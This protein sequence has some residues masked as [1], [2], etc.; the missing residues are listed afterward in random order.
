M[1]GGLLGLS[2]RPT[3]GVTYHYRLPFLQVSSIS[4]FNNMKNS[5]WWEG[6]TA[7]GKIGWFPSNFVGIVNTGRDDIVKGKFYIYTHSTKFR[8]KNREKILSIHLS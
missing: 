5:G 1:R 4:Q 8:S 2:L 6:T 7:D 3:V